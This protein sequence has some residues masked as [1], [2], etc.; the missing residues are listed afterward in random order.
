MNEFE[1]KLIELLNRLNKNIEQNNESIEKLS[2]IIRDYD[3]G[4]KLFILYSLMIF[5]ILYIIYSN[6]YLFLYLIP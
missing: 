4:N 3:Y 2:K 5:S 1:K 6:P